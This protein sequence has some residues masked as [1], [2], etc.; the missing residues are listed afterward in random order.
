[1]FHL[2]IEEQIWSFSYYI[3]VTFSLFFIICLFSTYCFH[4]N[5]DI[6]LVQYA[7]NAKILRFLYLLSFLYWPTFHFT[8]HIY[9][10][11]DMLHY[12]STAYILL[13]NKATVYHGESLYDITPL[14][15]SISYR[16]PS[17]MYWYF[18]QQT[19]PI[20]LSQKPPIFQPAGHQGQPRGFLFI[21]MATAAADGR[22]GC[23]RLVI[24]NFL[25]PYYYRNIIR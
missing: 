18:S 11:A 9:F 19:P 3:W 2:Q 14:M 7:K 16:W 25:Q 17:K 8:I 23:S 21:V 22:V 24:H 15:V 4:W 1:M 13:L 20:V 6:Y 12:F 10:Y 5:I